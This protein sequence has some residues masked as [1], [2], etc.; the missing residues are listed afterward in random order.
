MKYS[1][2][3]LLKDYNNNANINFLFFWGHKASKDGSITKSCFSQWW[4]CEFTIDGQTYN[5]A[6]QYMMAEKAKLFGDLQIFEKILKSTEPK[7]V[8]ALGRQV[9]NFDE[10]VWKANRYEIVKRGN[11]A[12]FSQ[13]KELGDFL[14]NTDNCVIVE[15]SP[16]DRIWGIGLNQNSPNA[17]NP[18]LWKGENLLGFALM[19]VRDE[20]NRS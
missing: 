9:A 5:S 3:K 15:A 13:N 4:P 1:L 10:A 20:L 19:E 17:N 16:Y 12:K 14:I 7:E 18:H 8:K 2:E 6:E 11:F